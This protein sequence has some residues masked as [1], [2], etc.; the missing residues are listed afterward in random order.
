MKNKFINALDCSNEILTP[1]IW[2]LEFHLWDKFDIGKFT[3]GVNFEKLTTL[4]KEYALN[5]NAETI[6]KV[7]ELLN[8]S[9]VTIPGGYWESSP[10]IPAFYYLPDEYRFK[11]AE[12]L[13]SIISDNIAL[14]ANCGGVMA[15]P[16]GNNYVDFSIQMMTDPNSID[17]IAGTVFEDS[18]YLIDRFAEIG[19][20]AILT[21]SDIA[22]SHGTYFSP[23]QLD[24]YIYP[25]LK[26]W[27]EY[28]NKLGLKSIMHTDGKINDVVA[29]IASSPVNGIQALDSTAGVDIVDIGSKYKDSLCVC[30]NIDCGLVLSSTPDLIY[31]A[32]TKLIS[33]MSGA[34]N[35]VIGASNA[36]E[37][38]TPSENYL[39]LINAVKDME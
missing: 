8:F 37:Y 10:G 24:R 18:L 28:I 17:V 33:E 39:S 16:E 27:S 1:P 35:F 7:S 36:L 20:D 4:Q 2:E 31:D 6:A 12:I 5:Q 14:V 25:Y 38:S 23:E 9:A 34:K 26:K 11:Q 32:T 29:S 3:V 30:G 15:M 19:V 13:K 22:D 21:A